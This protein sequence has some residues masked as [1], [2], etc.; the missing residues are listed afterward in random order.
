MR[1]RP[2]TGL[3]ESHYRRLFGLGRVQ[4]ASLLAQLQPCFRLGELS[5]FRRGNGAE[6]RRLID[7]HGPVM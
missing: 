2:G 1:E 4:S 3:F 6:S 7:K 5:T